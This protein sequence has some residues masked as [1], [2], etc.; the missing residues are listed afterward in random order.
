MVTSFSE[1]YIASNLTR[2]N[3]G[4]YMLSKTDDNMIK[5]Y[6][7]RYE[8]VI[9]KEIW[10]YG[11]ETNGNILAKVF[12]E[13]DNCNKYELLTPSTFRH[14]LLRDIS[15][16]VYDNKYRI[17]RDTDDRAGVITLSIINERDG[18]LVLRPYHWTNIT[19]INGNLA[20]IEVKNGVFVLYDLNNHIDIIGHEYDISELFNVVGSVYKYKKKG[21]LGYFLFNTKFA[22]D[23]GK[24]HHESYKTVEKLSDSII[25]LSLYESDEI[26]FISVNNK[27][28]SPFGISVGHSLKI[29]N[30]RGILKYKGYYGDSQK[31]EDIV[32]DFDGKK[33]NNK[34]S[35]Q[36]VEEK[37]R[38]YNHS[39]NMYITHPNTVYKCNE[40]TKGASI[41]DGYLSISR[42]WVYKG[43]PTNLSEHSISFDK[44]FKTRGIQAGKLVAWILPQAKYFIVGLT[45]S[46]DFLWRKIKIKY[47]EKLDETLFKAANS[48]VLKDKEGIFTIT[49]EI[50]GNKEDIQKLVCDKLYLQNNKSV[51]ANESR[52][53]PYKGINI[54]ESSKYVTNKQTR[55]N[56]DSELE[57][58]RLKE[59]YQFLHKKGFNSN[60]ILNSISILFPGYE[61][62]L[63]ESNN[64]V[65]VNNP[66]I[67]K[68]IARY[69]K[70]RDNR[71]NLD[72]IKAKLK[73]ND[74]QKSQLDYCLIVKGNTFV[75]ALNSVD[76][77]GNVSK[78]YSDIMK[79]NELLEKLWQEVGQLIIKE[80]VDYQMEPTKAF[81]QKIETDL[82]KPKKN[83]TGKVNI[84]L[85]DNS[86]ECFV[87]D[88]I[89]YS[90]FNNRKVTYSIDS[91][92]YVKIRHNIFLFLDKNRAERIIKEDNPVISNIPGEGKPG[93]QTFG[94]NNINTDLEKQKEKNIRVLVFER[95]DKENCTFFDEFEVMKV[96]ENRLTQEIKC[97][98]KSL[99]RFL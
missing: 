25:M 13:T 21:V 18:S 19:D 1:H 24:R 65:R 43:S 70:Y 5:I 89:N 2:N 40:P 51:A 62:R 96:E 34:P 53:Q 81:Q 22:T 31:P 36:S 16:E 38:E 76:V 55:K 95:H 66:A 30:N 83:Y 78:V 52:K 74:K 4:K 63:L 56:D 11:N 23:S 17:T 37:V 59:V 79:S 92:K 10:L 86:L 33:L 91:L 98:F 71:D 75:E 72:F 7:S 90:S 50:K 94:M 39:H 42:C 97:T 41:S 45:D 88:K 46:D 49:D 80:I 3:W 20:I 84:P 14:V 93:E 67:F 15:K 8:P 99:Y 32:M 68:D 60:D 29:D 77:S 48:L 28:F 64:D 61:H 44:S 54:E 26:Y 58:L 87:G 82:A 73:L 69:T 57:S 35:G 12:D 85:G 47:I 6:D 27:H 9:A